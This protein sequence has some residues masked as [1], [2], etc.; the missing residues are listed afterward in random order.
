M[1]KSVTL[2]VCWRCNGTGIFRYGGGTVNGRFVGKEGPCFKCIGGG[3]FPTT[4]GA[5]WFTKYGTRI[6]A[7]IE[8]MAK[9]GHTCRCGA[10]DARQWTQHSA[11][12][13]RQSK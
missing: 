10:E 13:I 1:S 3:Q 11:E 7:S 9:A 4:S 8:Q 2:Q 12:S 5:A 6:L